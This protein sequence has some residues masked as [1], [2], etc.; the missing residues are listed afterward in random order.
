MHRFIFPFHKV[1]T[2]KLGG[3]ESMECQEWIIGQ[4]FTIFLIP[5]VKKKSPPAAHCCE[6]SSQGEHAFDPGDSVT[7]GGSQD[8]HRI[9]SEM[10][11]SDPW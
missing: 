4:A 5:S 7:L 1:Q 3:V 10:V 11:S 6:S 8:R 9:N 2:A